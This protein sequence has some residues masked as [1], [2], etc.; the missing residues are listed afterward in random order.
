MH[1]SYSFS[2]KKDTALCKNTNTFITSPFRISKQNLATQQQYLKCCTMPTNFCV[3]AV[4]N[5]LL[6]HILLNSREQMIRNPREN[7][8]RFFSQRE[9]MLRVLL[10]RNEKRLQ[11]ITHTTLQHTFPHLLVCRPP[12]LA[13]TCL[14]A[15]TPRHQSTW[16]AAEGWTCHCMPAT[17]QQFLSIPF[18]QT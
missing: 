16:I 3:D 5:T 14:Q 8:Y 9:S 4:D 2:A 1:C 7:V 18:T 15:N 17:Q 13:Q 10:R 11:T 12:R 6:Q